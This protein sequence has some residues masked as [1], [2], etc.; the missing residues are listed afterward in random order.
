M[1]V[2]GVAEFDEVI[3]VG[4]RDRALTKLIGKFFGKIGVR[5]GFW[6]TIVSFCTDLVGVTD[7][8]IDQKV[9]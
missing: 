4:H 1:V 5:A 6:H 9:S 7:G 8:R 2:V 3:T